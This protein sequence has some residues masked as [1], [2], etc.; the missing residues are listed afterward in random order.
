MGRRIGRDDAEPSV[1]DQDALGERV[2][3][4]VVITP[5][6]GQV[7]FQPVGLFPQPGD[8]THWVRSRFYASRTG[9]L[10]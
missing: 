9:D 10:S 7:K 5:I 1:E 2:D 3:Q 4:Q 8:R 6:G